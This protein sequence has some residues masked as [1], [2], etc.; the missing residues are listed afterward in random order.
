MFRASLIAIIFW[1]SPLMANSTDSDRGARLYGRCTGCHSLD[2]D[3]TGPRHCGLIGRKAGAVPGFNYSKAM[4]NSSV[5]WSKKTLDAFLQNPRAFMP[6]N[7]MPY[8]GIK[9]DQ[10]RADLIA[11]L[12]AANNDPQQ[13]AQD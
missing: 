2:Y 12:V 13:C 3:R 8:A 6:G 10:D 11:F 1:L 4:K 7:H 5:L 9:N